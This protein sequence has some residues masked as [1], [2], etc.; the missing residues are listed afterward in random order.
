MGDGR[1][2]SGTSFE[3]PGGSALQQRHPTLRISAGLSVH[4]RT[5]TREI[6]FYLHYGPRSAATVH[7]MIAHLLFR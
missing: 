4:T 7:T 6:A 1:N 5:F 3:D 2:V